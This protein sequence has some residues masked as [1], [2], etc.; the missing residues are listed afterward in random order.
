MQKQFI[1]YVFVVANVM[2]TLENKLKSFKLFE[3]YL[4]LKKIFDNELTKML[5]E[6][7]YKNHIIDLI[8]NKKSLYILLYNLFQIEL[9]KLRRYLNNVLIKR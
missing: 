7:N 5:S 3:N 2:T 4:Y 8:K 9:T 1:I 6:Q